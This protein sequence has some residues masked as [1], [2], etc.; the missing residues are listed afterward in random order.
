MARFN[1]LVEQC[2]ARV[3]ELMPWDLEERLAEGDRPLILDVR[4]PYEYQAMHIAGSLNVPRGVLE[5]ACEWDFEE[6]VPEL[7]QAREREVVVVCRSGN[8]SLF[9][10][11]V[12]QELGY[13]RVLSLRTGLRGWA[14][15]EQPLVDGEDQPVSED[16]AE[17]YFTSRVRRDQLRPRP[18]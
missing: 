13:S 6:T 2:R 10:C 14:D 15:Y 16:A 7:V 11:D 9:A 18:D 3:R 17:D 12:M 4:E 1:E 8:R 5:T